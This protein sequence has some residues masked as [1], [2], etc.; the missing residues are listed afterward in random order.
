M[1][2]FGSN[3]FRPLEA[4]YSHHAPEPLWEAPRSTN[5]CKTLVVIVK[6]KWCKWIYWLRVPPSNLFQS[7]N[8]ELDITNFQSFLVLRLSKSTILV[9]SWLSSIIYLKVYLDLISSRANWSFRHLGHLGSLGDD[10]NHNRL[11]IT[12][13]LTIDNDKWLLMQ[14]RRSAWSRS[15]DHAP[16]ADPGLQ[17]MYPWIVCFY[18]L[19]LF[20]RNSIKS[21]PCDSNEQF[22]VIRTQKSG[23][24]ISPELSLV[25][26]D[27]RGEIFSNAA[28]LGCCRW[29]IE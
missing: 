5:G 28:V 25:S 6:E 24:L 22:D 15:T 11:R 4:Y 17:V 14:S 2:I 1:W 19:C 7:A 23:T 26:P 10:G 8:A 21:A 29:L 20:C 12:N 9:L 3:Q 13:R 18:F 16:A 27:T